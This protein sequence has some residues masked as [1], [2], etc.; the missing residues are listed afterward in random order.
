[1]AD[2][3]TLN[4][5]SGGD[6]IASDDISSAKYQRIK[7]VHGV[8]GT[9]DGDVA[10][11]NPL[12]VGQYF[13]TRADT[14]TATGN[15]TTVDVSAK[16]VRRFALQVKGTGATATVWTVRIEGSLDNTN[17]MELARHSTTNPVGNNTDGQI[18]WVEAGPFLYFR[19]RC[20]DT[21]TLGSATN[22]IA[23]IVGMQ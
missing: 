13:A 7:L 20:S 15:G 8:D 11:T 19:T 9:N 4:T 16:P 14:Y 1:M 6:V 3:T 10:K 17:F 5:G 21:L 23:T 12:P 2:N 22:I 18:I